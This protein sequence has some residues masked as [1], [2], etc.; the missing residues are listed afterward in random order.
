M[1][2]EL[3]WAS[4]LFDAPVCL[5]Q[6]VTMS[7]LKHIWLISN[8]FN[9][10]MHTG[11]FLPPPWQGDLELMR[12]FLQNGYQEPSMLMSLNHCRMHLHAFW[13]SN[14]CIGLGESINTG[15]WDS[16]VPCHL[17]WQWPKSISPSQSNWRMWQIALINSLNLS[18]SHWLAILLGPWISQPSPSGWY[19]KPATDHLWSVVEAQWTF[20]MP[21]PHLIR[22]K[23]YHSHG[24]HAKGPNVAA[25]R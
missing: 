3:G 25:L 22:N 16:H 20:F 21:L 10:C 7:W 13:L 8:S 11:V 9:I 14:L 24:Y 17:P 12:L 19:F 2:L 15:L 4:E 18:C 5:Q 23:L 6:V 1:L